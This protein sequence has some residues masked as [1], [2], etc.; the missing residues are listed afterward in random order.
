MKLIE[1]IA[2]LL[3]IVFMMCVTLFVG[4]MPLIIVYVC[5]ISEFDIFA[6]IIGCLITIPMLR[7]TLTSINWVSDLKYW[8]N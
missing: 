2:T 6:R 4:F 3:T 5:E 8:R 1:L 7:L